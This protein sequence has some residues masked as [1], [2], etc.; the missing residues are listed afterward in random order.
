MRNAIIIFGG[1]RQVK[2]EGCGRHR[3]VT[4]DRGDLLIHFHQGKI[5]IMEQHEYV[6]RVDRIVF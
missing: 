5:V 1:L 2:V 6:L 4:K 3:D